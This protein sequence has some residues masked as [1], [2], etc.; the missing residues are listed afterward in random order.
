M[1]YQIQQRRAEE[2]AELD[3]AKT[4]FFAHVSH[5]L[6]TPLTLIM[7]PLAE[8]R[9]GSVTSDPTARSDLDLHRANGLRLGKL[10][11]ALL[12]FS[13]IEAC[14]MERGPSRWI[15]GLTA[16]L[17]SIFRSADRSRPA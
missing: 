5:E 13:S 6:R 4:V 15:S 12:D 16:D 3:R 11:N 2:L 1:A 10:V 8:L 14:R 17:A 7:G 9:P